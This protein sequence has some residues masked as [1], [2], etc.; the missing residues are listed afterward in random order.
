MKSENKPQISSKHN[1]LS[2]FG[3][4]Y[5][6]RGKVFTNLIHCKP[7]HTRRVYLGHTCTLCAV[8]SLLQ[9][10]LSTCCF[11]LWVSIVAAVLSFSQQEILRPFLVAQTVMPLL[12]IYNDQN[13]FTWITNKYFINSRQLEKFNKLSIG[14]SLIGS[15]CGHPLQYQ[16]SSHSSQKLLYVCWSCFPNCE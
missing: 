8:S 4:T 13:N 16:C 10:Y 11:T 1:V 5:S 7:L 3:S 14:L 2:V 9:F 12:V 15:I 6:S